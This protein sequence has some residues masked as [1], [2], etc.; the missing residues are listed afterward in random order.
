MKNK[1]LAILILCPIFMFGWLLFW[2][3]DKQR[4]KLVSCGAKGINKAVASHYTQ[5]SRKETK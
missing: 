3:G 4:N 2:L 5:Q 1:L